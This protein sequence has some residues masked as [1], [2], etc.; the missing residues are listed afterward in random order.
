MIYLVEA[1][2]EQVEKFNGQEFA[3]SHQPQVLMVIFQ[4]APF[5]NTTQFDDTLQQT[6]QTCHFRRMIIQT[7]V[8]PI[9]ALFC[10]IQLIYSL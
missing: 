10:H 7:L 9:Q 6:I 8:M 5:V 3:K 1:I 2:F 4:L